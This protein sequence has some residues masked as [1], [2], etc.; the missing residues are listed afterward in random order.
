M[1]PGNFKGLGGKA[2]HL[3]FYTYPGR[4]KNFS[5][6]QA[7]PPG[8]QKSGIGDPSGDD[9]LPGNIGFWTVLYKTLLINQ[10]G[11]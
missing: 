8:S 2:L 9:L 5:D 7:N 11:Y 4:F 6:H 3:Q 1:T 10:P